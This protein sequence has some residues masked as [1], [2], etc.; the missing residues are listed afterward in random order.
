[1]KAQDL[2]IKILGLKNL[3]VETQGIFVGG[4]MEEL[5]NALR[6]FTSLENVIDVLDM[7]EANTGDSADSA[8]LED[9]AQYLDDES[10][11]E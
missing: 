1:M 4:S 10:E 8:T 7:Y 9:V 3:S 5:I 11:Y 6:K 2:R